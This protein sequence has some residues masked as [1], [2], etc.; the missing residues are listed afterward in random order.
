MTRYL[1]HLI[2]LFI[3]LGLAGCQTAV[4]DPIPTVNPAQHIIFHNGIVLTM[5]YGREDNGRWQQ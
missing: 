4:S 1:F 5:D 3:W 2:G